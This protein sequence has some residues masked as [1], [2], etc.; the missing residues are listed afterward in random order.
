MYTRFFRWASDRLNENGVLAFV[1][2]RSF[3]ES[4]TF[5]GFRKTVAQEFSDIY[6]VDLGGDVRANPKLSGTK[7][8]VFGVQT[9]VAISFF[10]KRAHKKTSTRAGTDVPPR[11]RAG[12]GRG[13]GARI[14]YVRRL[15]MET[16]E[17]KLTFL[18][19]VRASGLDFEEMA[20]D[21]GGNWLNRV[22]GE[23]EQFLPLVPRPGAKCIFSFG[24]N[25]IKTNRDDWVFDFSLEQ[26]KKKAAFQVERFNAQL[27][28]GTADADSLD[29]SIKW[30]S[31][32]KAVSSAVI[33]NDADFVE[34]AWRPFV[35]KRYFSHKAFSD[36]LTAHHYAGFGRDLSRK[37][38]SI[39]FVFGSR[40]EFCTQ[41]VI[42]N[43]RHSSNR[44]ET[45]CKSSGAFARPA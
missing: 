21:G 36:R 26:L 8:N 12:E 19:S 37:N 42:M 7:H 23:F 33:T 32:L 34:A 11:P 14:Y 45:L 43:E 24:A 30:S 9:G 17:E 39:C 3:I 38:R 29:Y 20:A 18:S 13:E 2:N 22:S 10:V 41:H 28:K 1:T 40:L 6:V 31:G 27:T 44:S 15:E 35:R 5:D 25:A 4:R 16:A